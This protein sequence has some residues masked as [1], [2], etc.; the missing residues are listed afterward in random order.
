[1]RPSLLLA[2]L[3]L[4]VAAGCSTTVS[5]TPQPGV[6]Q[7]MKTVAVLIFDDSGATDQAA[8]RALLGH[9]AESGSG[10]AMS[11]LFA[12]ALAEGKRYDVLR[13][14]R[15]ST[16][17]LAAGVDLKDLDRTEPAE[18]GKKLGVEGVIRGKVTSFRQ[19]WFLFLGWADVAFEVQ[20]YHVK[21]GK[22][23]WSASGRG[24]RVQGVESDLALAAS[25]K[26][27]AALP[28][29]PDAPAE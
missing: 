5:V 20:G 18:L 15:L 8:D 29:Q 23:A 16:R 13:G 4:C 10:R 2:L 11:K 26:I 24:F 27:A 21:T 14:S 19:S 6:P 9:T 28:A 22:A 17:C 25:R 12:Q 7:D 1:M 3:A